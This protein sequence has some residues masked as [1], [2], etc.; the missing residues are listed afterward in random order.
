MAVESQG[1]VTR[2]RRN[3]CYQSPQ[4]DNRKTRQLRMFK[5]IIVIMITFF[6]CRL[7]TWVYLLIKLN[8]DI[9]SSAGWIIHFSFGV[10]SLIACAINPFMYTF[11]SETI[12]LGTSFGEFLRSRSSLCH[13]KPPK[14]DPAIASSDHICM[15]PRSWWTKLSAMPSKCCCLRKRGCWSACSREDPLPDDKN[16]VDYFVGGLDDKFYRRASYTLNGTQ[17]VTNISSQVPGYYAHVYY[18]PPDP[19]KFVDIDLAGTR[20]IM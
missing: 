5:V 16:L 18:G 10:L 4:N 12:R 1:T 8:R 2:E 17:S 3:C 6:L 7:P 20:N 9:S 11:L 14:P 19:S 15:H 13:R